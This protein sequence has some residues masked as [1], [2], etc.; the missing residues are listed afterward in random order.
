MPLRSIL[1][2][3]VPEQFT[4]SDGL[5]AG[6]QRRTKTN[7]A[8]GTGFTAFTANLDEPSHTLVAR[9][10]KDG[11]ECLIPQEGKNPRLLTPRECARLQ[12]FPE[13]F[14]LPS[15][16]SVAYKQMGNSVAVPVLQRIAECIDN[17]ILKGVKNGV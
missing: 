2:R 7:L 3:D 15:S 9:Y 8:R 6:H 5:W 1:E 16:R 4:I 10:Y 13:D 17:Q 11:K 14:R 12:G